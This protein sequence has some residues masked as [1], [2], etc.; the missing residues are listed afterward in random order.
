M[1]PPFFETAKQLRPTPGSRVNNHSSTPAGRA[2]QHEGPSKGNN[3]QLP[4]STLSADLI[5]KNSVDC[6]QHFT[7][8]VEKPLTAQQL[9]QIVPL[10][11]V[12]LL[13]WAREGRI[14]HRRLSARKIVFLPSE[15]NAWLASDSAGY[16]EHAGRAAQP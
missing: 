7:Q 14:P 12:T 15:I 2:A 13:R 1:T 9:S 5:S 11:P 4:A 3:V 6:R 8:A 10:H 16:T